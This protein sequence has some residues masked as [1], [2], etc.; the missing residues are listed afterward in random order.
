MVSGFPMFF[1][2]M[3]FSHGFRSGETLGDQLVQE[4]LHSRMS[5]VL[6]KNE[7]VKLPG[8]IVGEWEYHW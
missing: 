6:R 4:V 7:Q 1:F 5:R 2:P 8:T 3:G